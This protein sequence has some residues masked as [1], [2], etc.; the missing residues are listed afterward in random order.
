MICRY[1][2]SDKAIADLPFLN[3]NVRL[4]WNVSILVLILRRRSPSRLQHSIGVQL[5]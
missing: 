1:I 4:S 5:L 3:G 2:G